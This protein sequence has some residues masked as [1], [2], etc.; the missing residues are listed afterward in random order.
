MPV[1]SDP[2]NPPF[3]MFFN[4]RMINH[5]KQMIL[6]LQTAPLPRY[7]TDKTFVSLYN[8]ESIQQNPDQRIKHIFC[9]LFLSWI[10]MTRHLILKS[11]AFEY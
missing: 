3:T 5:L 6:L 9:Q 4:A 1:F 11:F 7:R 8:I 10:G 2:N